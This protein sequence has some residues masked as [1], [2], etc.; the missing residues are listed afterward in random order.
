MCDVHVPA[1]VV[2]DN[3]R[4][5]ALLYLAVTER[6]VDS[7]PMI[8]DGLVA[9]ILRSP[10]DKAVIESVLEQLVIGGR[11][12]LSA[13]TPPRW[14]GVLFERNIACPLSYV[15]DDD[16]VSVHEVDPAVV[17]GIANFTGGNWTEEKLWA[18]HAKYE[19][20]LAKWDAVAGELKSRNPDILMVLKDIGLP[21][22][23][24]PSVEQMAA[25]Q[26]LQ[27][28]AHGIDPIVR[29][30]REY[31]TVLTHSL[32]RDALSSVP[33]AASVCGPM[34]LTVGEVKDTDTREVVLKITAPELPRPPIG[35]TLKETITLAISPAGDAYRE[36]LAGWAT[37]L[38]GRS[39]EG[40]EII[41]REV[42]TARHELKF[43]Q[44]LSRVGE[45]TTW[46]GGGAWAVGGGA[47]AAG[48]VL[49]AAAAVG[50]VATVV[51]VI[52]LSGDKLLKYRNRWAMF[53]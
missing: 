32:A 4:S 45:Y 10:P 23:L 42:Q 17:L 20:A 34:K 5:R 18:F 21:D 41:V 51:G 1:G 44:A 40:I 36:K 46:V 29:A 48:F 24:R 16:L 53:G 37:L 2:L 35:R 38:R 8:G 30:M 31:R 26:E 39:S 6:L 12:F 27:D 19:G 15:S 25:W 28:A 13:W 33:L 43:S 14:S 49:P 7:D 22:E 11:L 3:E 47:L 9:S 52:A 50:G